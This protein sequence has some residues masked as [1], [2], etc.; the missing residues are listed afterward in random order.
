[1]SRASFATPAR[2]LSNFKI[3]LKDALELGV[4]PPSDQGFDNE[5]YKALLAVAKAYPSASGDLVKAS[6]NA[7]LAQLK[8]MDS[9]QAKS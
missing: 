4:W 7:L 9:A 2:I 3:C 6:R 1:M 8:M 5:T